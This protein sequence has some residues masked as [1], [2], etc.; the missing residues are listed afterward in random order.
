[1][2]S[3]SPTWSAAR[4]WTS[5]GKAIGPVTGTFDSGA[6]ELLILDVAGREEV[7]LPFVAPMLVEVDLAARRAWSTTRHRG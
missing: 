1:M 7:L 2:S 6:H 4:W 3:T 5:S